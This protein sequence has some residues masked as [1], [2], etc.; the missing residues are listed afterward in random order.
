MLVN[1]VLYTIE[2]RYSEKV[3]LKKNLNMHILSAPGKWY[4]FLF[5]NFLFHVGQGISRF[6]S[7]F[8]NHVKQLL[9]VYI[10]YF[11]I[12][13]STESTLYF[14]GDNLVI[15]SQ[16]KI[17]KSD[18]SVEKLTL[19]R[20]EAFLDHIC[21]NQQHHLDSLHLLVC[22]SSTGMGRLRLWAHEDVLHAG[23]HQR[24]QVNV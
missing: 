19:C 17:T 10:W 8:V 1:A 21:H 22:C 23:L 5:I 13:L 6:I 16:L 11:F 14:V 18:F 9:N 24:G 15:F 3:S 20:T 2:M 4:N 12:F 7:R